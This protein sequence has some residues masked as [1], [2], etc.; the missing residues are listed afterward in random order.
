[1]KHLKRIKNFSNF[2]NSMNSHPSF[3]DNDPSID[4][5]D[6]SRY[7]KE[8]NKIFRELKINIYNVSAFPL[9]IS[10]LCTF[11]KLL[12]NK[13]DITSIVLLTTCAVSLILREDKENVIKLVSYAKQKGIEQPEIDQI[14][15][16]I[17]SIKKIFTDVS[18]KF[19]KN[20][21]NLVDV[22]SYTELFIPFM[23]IIISLINQKMIDIDLISDPS[24]IGLTINDEKYK[25][26]YDRIIHKL[27]IVINNTSKFQ[28]VKN[29]K[30]LRIND[31]LKSDRF[32]N[33]RIQM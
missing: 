14:I 28:D 32:K 26:L 4:S 23:T 24:L 21:S 20:I 25:H 5:T 15:V 33:P 12:S 13:T 10:Y 11:V 1:M 27:L 18:M 6:I 30:I 17:Q 3:M 22:L 9:S 2:T 16:K 7:Q 8:Y 19:E 31:E 29:T